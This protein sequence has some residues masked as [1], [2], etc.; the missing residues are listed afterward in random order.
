[1]IDLSKATVRYAFSLPISELPAKNLWQGGDVAV[2]PRDGKPYLFQM[3]AKDTGPGDIEDTNVHR[4]SLS[5]KAGFLSGASYLDTMIGKG[6]GHNQTLKTRISSK[7]NVYHWLGIESY[8]SKNQSTGTALYRVLHKRGIVTKADS[9]RIYT[10]SGS[11]APISCPD[12]K[13]VLRRGSADTETYEWFDEKTLIDRAESRLVSGLIPVGRPLPTTSIT[14]PRGNTTYQT[15]AAS[16]VEGNLVRFNG[17]TEDRS[18]LTAFSPQ[19]VSTLD[20]TNTAPPKLVVTSEEPEISF[21]YKGV[22]YFGKRYNST[23]KRVVAY[24]SVV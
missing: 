8:N 18:I 1:M 16:P 7:G 23:A 2:D 15:S 4:Y 22:L 14:V 24:F 3:Q 12:F 13:I 6:F 10:G 17:A 11:V 9:N 20:V 19:W 5:E 21:W